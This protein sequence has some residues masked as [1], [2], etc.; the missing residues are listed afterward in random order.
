MKVTLLL[1]SLIIVAVGSAHFWSPRSTATDAA[2]ASPLGEADLNDVLAR[3][4]DLP[5]IVPGKSTD[6]DMR[7]TRF[8]RSNLDETRQMLRVLNGAK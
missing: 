4:A 2:L 5:T 1:T 3:K 7:P 6:F 8:D